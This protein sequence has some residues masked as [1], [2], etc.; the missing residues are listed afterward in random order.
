MGVYIYKI[1]T[2]Y[3]LL[4][5][6]G[7]GKIWDDGSGR[8]STESGKQKRRNEGIRKDLRGIK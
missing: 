5:T 4:F 3:L 8:G 6:K 1:D 7:S 2:L